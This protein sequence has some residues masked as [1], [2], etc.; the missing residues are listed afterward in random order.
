MEWLLRKLESG[1]Q[2]IR[3]APFQFAGV[4][5]VAAII[6]GLFWY[7]IFSTALRIQKSTIDAYKDRYGDFSNPKN[8]ESINDI[9]KFIVSETITNFDGEKIVLEHEPVTNSIQMYYYEGNPPQM[10]FGLWP[11]LVGQEAHVEG[12]TIVFNNPNK[13]ETNVTVRVDYFRKN[14]Q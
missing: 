11:P 10:Q 13:S 6:L 5:F 3:G 8:P 4:C 7:G 1:Q 14:L 12:K 2:M 9:S